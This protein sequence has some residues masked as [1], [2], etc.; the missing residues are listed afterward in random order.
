MPKLRQE[1]VVCPNVLSIL[2]DDLLRGAAPDFPKGV[3]LVFHRG[4]RLFPFRNACPFG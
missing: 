1:F 2:P 3:G 4:K